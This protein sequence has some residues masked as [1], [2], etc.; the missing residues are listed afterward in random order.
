MRPSL[1]IIVL[2][3]S[4]GVVA[5]Q[6]YDAAPVVSAEAEGSGGVVRAAFDIAAP[7]AVVWATL[8]DCAGAAGFMPKLISCKVVERDPAGRWEIREHKL[9]GGVLKPV[10]RNVFRADFKP[11]RE[12]AFQR[13]DGDWKRSD[14]AWRLTPLAGGKAT[15]VTYE[16]HVAVNGPVPAAL[17]RGAV[18]KGAP[19]AMLALRRECVARLRNAASKG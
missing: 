1:P 4:A 11:D 9:R 3:A 18:A 16:I 13:V 17:V 8:T 14:G 5:A 10:M 19:E 7:P 12:L 2:L 6:G 15:H